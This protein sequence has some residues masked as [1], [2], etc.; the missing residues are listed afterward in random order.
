MVALALALSGCASL[1]PCPKFSVGIYPTQK[2]PVFVI[3]EANMLIMAG[4]MQ[5]L[6]ERTCD[7]D[8]EEPKAVT[9]PTPVDGPRQG[10]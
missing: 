9:E 4:R 7:P 10:A 5:Q 2:G 1:P 8:R 6:H 3:D